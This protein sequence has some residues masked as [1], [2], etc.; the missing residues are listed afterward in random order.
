MIRPRAIWFATAAVA[1]GLLTSCSA[2]S[3]AA[4]V[5]TPAAAP[6]RYGAPEV[7]SPR[8][9]SGVAA[10]PCARLLT[11]QDLRSL[12]FPGPGRGR[13]LV[14]IPECVWA[15][16]RDERLSI[17]VDTRRDLLADTYRT[18]LLPIFVPT[19]VEGMPAVRQRMRPDD[20][21]CTVTTGLG[22]RQALETEWSGLSTRQTE[23]PCAKAEEAIALVVRKLPPQR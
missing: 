17:A 19:T 18:R 6:L 20:N 2:G 15:N 16:G 9:A 11:N 3:G 13:T 21:T 1:V 8:D 12:G 14:D 7:T 23:D 4:P 22:P 5:S 10:E